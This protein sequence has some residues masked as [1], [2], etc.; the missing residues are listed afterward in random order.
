VLGAEIKTKQQQIC[1]AGDFLVAEIDAKMGGYG[2]VPNDLADAI[3]SSHYFLY[4][5]DERRLIRDFLAWFIKTPAFQSQISAQGS[6]NYSAI[7]PHQVL[8]YII[9][10]PPK[11]EQLRIVEQ[12]DA[13]AELAA[14]VDVLRNEIA[15]EL[16]MLVVVSNRSYSREIPTRFG[17][18]ISLN[19][20]RVIIEPGV[21]Y[22]QIGIRGFGGGLF[23][24][25]P[26][27][28]ESTSYR[29]FNR[30]HEGHFVVSQVKGWEGA[31]AVCSELYAGFF[32]SPE[33]RTFR[34]TP[35]L[36]R[37]SYLA[38]LCR[39][40]WFHSFLATLTRGQGARRE[41]LRPEMLVDCKLPLPTVADQER[42]E[43]AFHKAESA[44]QL[45]GEASLAKLIPS[46]IDAAF[47]CEGAE[48]NIIPEQNAG[49]QVMGNQTSQPQFGGPGTT[50]LQ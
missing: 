6:T 22:P 7:R 14:K 17:D 47:K 5:I 36:L 46:L 24:K 9:P 19:E 2:I 20:D 42:L 30:L 31:V 40:G 11:A 10:L 45:T 27:R 44:Q 35:E 43:K 32:A 13:A 16:S 39:T 12:L 23:S 3:V 48:E 41:R 50:L 49:N 34:C 26:V 25:P 15:D 4:T 38:F 21:D 33:Y 28:A 1:E 18:A 29:Y 37:P 8:E